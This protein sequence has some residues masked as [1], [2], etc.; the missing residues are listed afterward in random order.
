MVARG[1]TSGSLV[2]RISALEV[3]SEYLRALQRALSINYLIQTFH[4]WLPSDRRCRGANLTRSRGAKPNTD[5]FNASPASRPS[6]T[7]RCS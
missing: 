7:L 4:V 6:L 1:E 2:L 3:R 5:G